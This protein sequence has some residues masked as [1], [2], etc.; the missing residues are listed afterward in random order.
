MHYK[1]HVLLLLQRCFHFPIKLW[2]KI[3]TQSFNKTTT[4]IIVLTYFEYCFSQS[5]TT[6]IHIYDVCYQLLYDDKST[7]SC[8]QK[9][10]II[11]K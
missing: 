2:G 5:L 11:N 1:N 7:R 10:N 9:G 3:Q 6:E 8:Y 4:K